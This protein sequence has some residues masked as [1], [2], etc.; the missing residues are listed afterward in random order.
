MKDVVKALRKYRPT[1]VLMVVSGEAHDSN[2]IAAVKA[3][4]KV[5]I[6]WPSGSVPLIGRKEMRI[7]DYGRRKADQCAKSE[8]SLFIMGEL[9][10][11]GSA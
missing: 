7:G 3:K 11:Q 10:M 1:W 9:H 4:A 5:L 6:T 2:L 8:V